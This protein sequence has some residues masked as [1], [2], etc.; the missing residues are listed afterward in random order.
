MFLNAFEWSPHLNIETAFQ[1]IP[2]LHRSALEPTATSATPTPASAISSSTASRESPT[3]SSV[4]QVW[5]TMTSGPLVTGPPRD[6]DLAAALPRKVPYQQLHTQ[7][8]MTRYLF[9]IA[10]HLL[11]RCQK[12][13]AQNNQHRPEQTQ[14]NP[15]SANAT[16]IHLSTTLYY[17]NILSVGRSASRNSFS[18][19]AI[20]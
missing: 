7:T 19:G 5:S 2:K 11:W 13:W 6:A 3:R 1:R 4:H 17:E 14:L 15:K 9:G 20:I 16:K 8:P 12:T 10:L 18:L